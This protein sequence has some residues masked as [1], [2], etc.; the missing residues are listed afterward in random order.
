MRR[1]EFIKV[2]A[3]SAVLAWPLRARSRRQSRSS[4]F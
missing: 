2:V 1:R 4:V 3:G